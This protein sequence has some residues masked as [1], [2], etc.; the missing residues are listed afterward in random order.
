MDSYNSLS[1]ADFSKLINTK[2]RTMLDRSIRGTNN[3]LAALRLHVFKNECVIYNGLCVEQQEIGN[4][5]ENAAVNVV[6]PTNCIIHATAC[7]ICHLS[8][9]TYATVPASTMA[10]FP[11]IHQ[12]RQRFSVPVFAKAYLSSF[13]RHI[14]NSTTLRSITQAEEF[15]RIDD[16]MMEAVVDNLEWAEMTVHRLQIVISCDGINSNRMGNKA[17]QTL[18]PIVYQITSLPESL[19]A[20][21]QMVHLVALPIVNGKGRNVIKY[22]GK[23]LHDR[24]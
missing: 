3:E 1:T 22:F 11:F 10:I 7:P 14:Y 9:Y 19:N 16:E 6:C 13:K 4:E 20:S 23:K 17:K 5:N 12:L 8:R 24:T 21:K 18:H 2:F 15:Q